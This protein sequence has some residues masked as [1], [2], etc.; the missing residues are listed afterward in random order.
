MK[1]L[2]VLVAWH[3]SGWNGRICR[4]PK[5]NKFCES[6]GWVRMN[7]FG[8][9]LKGYFK[10]LRCDCNA[11]K[12]A[13]K[14]SY[15]GIRWIA[16]NEVNMFYEFKNK[17][18]TISRVP[19]GWRYL[20]IFNKKKI[21]LL[22]N[23]FVDLWIDFYH[24]NYGLS[25][26]YC[27]DNPLSDNKIL[28]A[29]VKPKKK[30]VH[31]LYRYFYLD[32]MDKT[33]RG[34]KI[35][36]KKV[37]I[38]PRHY[39]KLSDLN[40]YTNYADDKNFKEAFVIPE[41]EYN[42]EDVIFIIPYQEL[43]EYY[44]G[45][46][47]IPDEFILE[48]PKEAQ[49]YFRYS[50]N[51]LPN[52]LAISILEQALKIIEEINKELRKDPKL[53]NCLKMF[54]E[55]FMNISEFPDRIKKC[56]EELKGRKFKYPG[57]PSILR[58]LGVEN[59]VSLYIDSVEKDREEEM[60]HTVK[61]AL[62]NNKERLKYG[63]NRGALNSYNKISDDIKHFLID[64][65]PY[66]DLTKGDIE[67][68]FRQ[69]DK[70]FIDIK[71]VLEN[72]YL[73]YEDI[74][75]KED[76][77]ITFQEIDGWEANRLGNR[78]DMTDKRRIRALLVAILKRALNDGHT[79]IPYCEGLQSVK[80]DL[81]YY[82]KQINGSLPEDR[83]IDFERLLE[84]ILENLDKDFVDFIQEKVKIDET[85]FEDELG[86]NYKIK[87]FSLKEIDDKGEFIESFIEELTKK[88]YE[89]K[90]KDDE[91]KSL[92]RGEKPLDISD[93]EFEKALSDQ[94]EALK[95]IIK[96]G[97]SILTGSAGTGKTHVIKALLEYICK[98]ENPRKVVVL[99]PTGKA[100]VRIRETVDDVFDKYRNIV[101]E[102]KTIHRFLVENYDF[103]FDYMLFKEPAKYV[104]V[105]TL[106]VDEASMIG[107][108]LL[109]HLLN[110]VNQYYL[111][112]LVLVE[113]VNQLP[114]IEAGKPFFDLYNYLRQKEKNENKKYIARLNICLRAD[115]KR[116]FEF[117]RLYEKA[118]LN[119][120]ARNKETIGILLGEL[121]KS[122]HKMGDIVR[123]CLKDEKDAERIVIFECSDL[124]K[125]LETAIDYMIEAN[126]KDP[127]DYRNF[128]RLFVFGDNI[129]ILTPTKVKG[130]IGSYSINYWIRDDSKYTENVKDAFIR[131]DFACSSDFADK[132]IQTVNN[133]KLDVWDCNKKCRIKWHGVFNGMMGYIAYTFT[134]EKVVRFYFPAVQVFINQI[135]DQ[136]EYAYAITTHKAQGSEF[137]DVI[138]VF[139]SGLNVS[140]ELIYTA[141]TR[142]RSKLV[143][144]T[145]NLDYLFDFNRY[146]ELSRRYSNLF[147]N[148]VDPRAYPE[149]LRV[150]TVRG[151]IV[152]SWQECII[153]NL[154]YYENIDYEYE[155]KIWLL[156][157]PI[158]ADFK[159]KSKD[160]RVE[161]IWEHLGMDETYYKDRLE[162]YKQN[163][164]S[165]IKIK[166]LDEKKVGKIKKILITSC[167]D[168]IKN[169]RDLRSKIQMLREILNL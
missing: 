148:P 8:Y 79:V 143:I 32:R 74:K 132:V 144:V 118:M 114:P 66:Y 46:D 26:V 33:I 50:I 98:Y 169:T 119:E 115:S 126:N 116:I 49:K 110:C 77:S 128:F 96:N 139:P 18:N 92:L 99:A 3:D 164:F 67:E 78:F 53:A 163:G 20:K 47:K 30:N 31:M 13:D 57:L 35:D 70:G 19:Y 137:D 152:R 127:N 161:I 154:L 129:Q 146:S 158:I 82:F 145:D 16:C 10:N 15:E 73:L 125:A 135:R 84:L 60:Y 112:R 94:V 48:I 97:C 65:L 85:E 121:Y 51:F 95:T 106:I 157:I 22:I 59:A 24:N 86:R 100:S 69:K 1:H 43:A 89:V 168:D 138:F 64:Y 72:P 167:T 103:D 134:G 160:N 71:K 101:E 136:L 23:K 25:F 5:E 68:L 102:P 159:L 17:D 165:I 105:D 40:L 81:E 111:K 88:S 93:D 39:A 142:A 76:F 104:S 11:N 122:R 61:D 45:Y 124:Y 27:R 9:H 54:R 4:Y 62:A 36:V 108:E 56:L 7:K 42:I 55:K 155:P 140:R 29:C 166:D 91:L 133:W 109:Y 6:F 34:G 80:Y 83:R 113:D 130:K 153:A 37:T 75:T 52:N 150:I 28:C 131:S 156:N 107:I 141:I 151:E 58:F 120:N 63:I 12:I 147:D 44:N 162:I 87:L 38:N 14:V 149:H 90:A 21:Y 117:S 123:Y 2:T 41:I